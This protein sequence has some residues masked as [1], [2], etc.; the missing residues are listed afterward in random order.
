MSK[1]FNSAVPAYVDFVNFL[2]ANRLVWHYSGAGISSR[3]TMNQYDSNPNSVMKFFQSKNQ[4]P[5]QCAVPFY[6]TPE[7]EYDVQCR[8][9]YGKRVTGPWERGSNL[10]RGDILKDRFLELQ[11]AIV[12]RI[13]A[14]GCSQ[15]QH[16]SA[17]TNAETFNWGG[18]FS[19]EGDL[20]FRAYLKE[21]YSI[22]ILQS[23]GIDNIDTFLYSEFLRSKGAPGGEEFAPAGTPSFSTWEGKSD[24]RNFVDDYQKFSEVKSAEY[25]QLLKSEAR[26]TAG[27]EVPISGNIL[28]LDSGYPITSSLDF[29][30]KEL[31]WKY[32]SPNGLIELSL[33]GKRIGKSVVTTLPYTDTSLN[34]VIFASSYS[35]GMH[36]ILPFDV[37]IPDVGGVA[38]PRYSATIE[39]FKDLTDFVSQNKSLFDDYEG[40]QTYGHINNSIITKIETIKG[41]GISSYLRIRHTG[42]NKLGV[43][44]KNAIVEINGRQYR[45]I[46]NSTIGYIYLPENLLGELQVGSPVQKV[47]NPDNS[48]RLFT[49]TLKSSSPPI[50]G[51][52][53][54]DGVAELELADLASQLP[55]KDG[56][57]LIGNKWY[58]AVQNSVRSR[59]SLYV[60]IKAEPTENLIGQ[61]FIKAISPDSTIGI[62]FTIPSKDAP[63]VKHID[64]NK[65][66]LG[67]TTVRLTKGDNEIHSGSEYAFAQVGFTGTSEISSTDGSIYLMGDHRNKLS[68]GQAVISVNNVSKNIHDKYE[69]A[70]TDP[71]G[72]LWITQNVSGFLAAIKR[73]KNDPSKIAIHL[74]NW[75]DTPV[76]T[77]VAFRPLALFGFVP[78]SCTLLEAGQAPKQLDLIDRSELNKSAY[79]FDVTI[80][81]WGIVTCQQ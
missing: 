26:S 10:F 46:N 75:K 50:V 34:R 48:G 71:S 76:Y 41:S 8:D 6:V 4:Y 23:R 49:T 19:Q 12:R 25:L 31:N 54:Q 16:D 62:D 2:N 20:K 74:V 13:V 24:P 45:A 40:I 53:Y 58:T 35:L 44:S 36:M 61:P 63:R 68:I 14:G 60:Y 47:I 9:L 59:S 22:E 39:N 5:V 56:Q 30:L 67:Y 43:V 1:R 28:Y 29:V 65:S 70:P 64:F 79:R 69:E 51:V 37:Y 32:R 66:K 3:K 55:A 80:K 78:R 21:K 11:S 38:Q 42:Q 17:A 77:G 7:E 72:A 15:L 81:T 18:C 57:V 73:K 52:K 27:F 33:Q